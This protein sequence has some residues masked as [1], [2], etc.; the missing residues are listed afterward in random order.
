MQS[1]QA[2]VDVAR[3]A[4]RAGG[5][6]AMAHFA[7]GIAFRTKA[8]ST[9]V[10]DADDAAEQAILGCIRGA[11]PDHRILSE[12]S[13]RHGE[14]GHHEW[15]VDP[16][17]GTRGFVRGGPFWG[18]LVALRCDGE[19]LAGAMSLPVSGDLYWA[20]RGL[21]AYHDGEP[22]RLSTVD[23]WAEATLSLGEVQQILGSAVA[24]G[25]I[26]L[27]RTAASVRAYGDV[28]SAKMVLDGKAEVF[29]ECGVKPWDL[30]PYPVLFSEAGGR[31]TDLAGGAR[32]DDGSAVFSNGALHDVVLAALSGGD[33]AAG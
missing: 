13:G 17:D 28:G 12:E 18:A 10:T 29:L 22:L 26:E 32:F 33:A 23:T 9:W 2:F 31:A 14:D 15:L 27:A 11:F 4:A 30:G 6:A 7:P 8:D 1:I 20:G 25:A 3:E 24:S 5:A 16:L 21:G 19:V